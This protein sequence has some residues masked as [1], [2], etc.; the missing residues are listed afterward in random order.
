MNFFSFLPYVTNMQKE[1]VGAEFSKMYDLE[2]AFDFYFCEKICKVV[3][4]T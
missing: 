3:H 4:E 1:N 2:K